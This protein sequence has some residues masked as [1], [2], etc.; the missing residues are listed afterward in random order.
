MNI[1]SLN[2]TVKYL[3]QAEAAA[4]DKTDRQTS[5]AEKEPVYT[6]NRFDRYE[7]ISAANSEAISLSDP[8]QREKGIFSEN[9]SFEEGEKILRADEK[10]RNY[11]GEGFSAKHIISVFFDAEAN[12]RY[13]VNFT[14]E[15]ADPHEPHH[16]RFLRWQV[17]DGSFTNDSVALVASQ[18]G[19]YIDHC[20]EMGKYTDEEYEELNSEIKK[21]SKAWLSEIIDAK[22]GN[23]LLEQDR[24]MYYGWSKLSPRNSLEEQREEER[25]MRKKIELEEPVDYDAFFLKID[26]MR[27]NVTGIKSNS[28]ENASAQ[29]KTN[30]DQT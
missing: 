12:D 13:G 6:L 7:G 19:K 14:Y 24:R 22:A 28:D 23:R 4:A 27:F 21:C 3:E 29:A 20:Y 9:T 10:Y 2:N 18:V 15:H 8:P 5:A 16:E 26:Q 11:E 17:A 30:S 25:L 1:T